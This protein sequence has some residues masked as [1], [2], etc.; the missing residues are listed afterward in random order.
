MNRL[1]KTKLIS[2]LLFLL[3]GTQVKVNA[4]SIYASSFGYNATNATNAFQNAINSAYDTVIFSKQSADWFINP[5]TFF[6]RQNKVY[7]FLPGVKIRS[8]ANQFNGVYDCLMQFKE[9]TNIKLIGYQAEFAMNKAEYVALN[10]SEERHALFLFNCV[11]VTVKGLTIRDS[12]GDGIYVGGD[13]AGGATLFYCKNVFIED[14]RCI[15]NYRQGMSVLSAQDMQV[16]NCLFTKTGGTL[17]EAGVDLEPYLPYQRITNIVFDHCSFTDNGYSGITLALSFLDATSSPVSV[18]VKDCYFKNNC[19]TNISNPYSKGEITLFNNTTSEVKGT[20]LFERIFV[21]GS[22]WS[23]IYSS[24]T[25][26]GYKTTFKDCV[27]KNVAQN[28]SGN[29]DYNSPIVLEVPSYD[30]TTAAMGNLSF[31]NVLISYNKSASYMSVL[32]FSPTSAVANIDGNFTLVQPVNNGVAYFGVGSTSNLTFTSNSQTSLPATNASLTVG[33]SVAIECNGQAGSF[34]VKRSSTRINYPLGFT[35]D[36]TGSTVKQG[37]DIHLIPTGVVIANNL[38]TKS[39]TIVARKDGS[40]EPT[41]LAKIKL[42]PGS[43]YSIVSGSGNITINVTDCSST[44]LIAPGKTD[45]M[46]NCTVKIYPNPANE[47]LIIQSDIASKT[48]VIIIADGLGKVLKQ[49]RINNNIEEINISAFPIG[50]YFLQ[51]R[52][53]KGNIISAQKVVKAAK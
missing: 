45:L 17:P 47:K 32:G 42:V 23:G 31:N 21:D 30:F 37:D 10:N 40:T 6:N 25:I 53:T 16:R 15:N 12:G 19:V 43:L 50:V 8:R 9:C 24:N 35:I 46:H 39:E 18:T 51:I 34:N 27:F 44:P 5:S 4:T 1:T 20:V 28:M 48:A 52:D 22:Q 3:A 26:N 2:F 33:T 41:E 36:T 7:I 29:P 49:Q 11:D 13:K 14:V 38:T